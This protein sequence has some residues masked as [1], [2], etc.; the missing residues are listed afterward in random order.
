MLQVL[1][2]YE[3]DRLSTA[4]D[5][6]GNL[7]CKESAELYGTYFVTASAVSPATSVTAYG[8]SNSAF[9]TT[10]GAS[11]SWG[12]SP[13]IDIALKS[14]PFADICAGDKG[15]L[16]SGSDYSSTQNVAALTF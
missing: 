4:P 5:V 13:D 12:G 7:V 11:S 3:A 10:S 16:T 15:M 8:N 6:D 2:I 14:A 1:K 9:E